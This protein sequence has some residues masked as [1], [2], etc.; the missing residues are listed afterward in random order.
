MKLVPQKKLTGLVQV[1]NLEGDATITFC[2]SQFL[3]PFHK[4]IRPNLTIERRRMWSSFT[5]EK[6]KNNRLKKVKENRDPSFSRTFLSV[7]RNSSEGINNKIKTTS[8]QSIFLPL[9]RLKS[10]SRKAPV[11]LACRLYHSKKLLKR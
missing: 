11:F 1:E 4:L 2:F 9:R 7:C 6:M 3:N 8:H 5:L 10:I